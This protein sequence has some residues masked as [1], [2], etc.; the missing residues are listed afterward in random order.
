MAIESL[1][2]LAKRGEVAEAWETQGEQASKT[3]TQ[4]PSL[5]HLSFL[6]AA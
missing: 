4:T 3:V 6:V 2:D 5:A 1:L